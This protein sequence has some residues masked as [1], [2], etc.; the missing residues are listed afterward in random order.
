MPLYEYTCECGKE[1]EAIKSIGDRH[2]VICECGKVSNL[3]ISSWGKVVV[4]GVFTVIG[5]DGAV[6]DKRQTTE[7]TPL[8]LP[9]G[10]E[11]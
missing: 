6:L 7:R 3:K 1:F 11:Y 10:R 8:R 4:A 9:S 2:N 5:H